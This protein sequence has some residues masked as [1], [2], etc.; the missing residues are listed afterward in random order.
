MTGADVIERDFLGGRAG[1][2]ETREN[3][4]LGRRRVG[5]LL[6]KNVPSRRPTRV[7]LCDEE[8]GDSLGAADRIDKNP[9]LM[10]RRS[11][12]RRNLG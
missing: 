10:E 8:I 7:A 1:T 4:H 5:E 2:L 9:Q 3:V 12:A 6:R 11:A